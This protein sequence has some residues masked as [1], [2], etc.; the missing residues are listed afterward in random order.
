MDYGF[1]QD[2][3]LPPRSP[4]QRPLTSLTMLGTTTGLSSAVLTTRKGDTVHARIGY[5]LSFWRFFPCF[6]AFFVSK[7]AIFPLKRSVL[8]AW[9][10]NFRA[11]KRQMVVLGFQDPKTTWNAYKTREDVTTPQLA[12]PHGLA[13]KWA[14]NC[15]KTVEKTPKGQMV[16]NSRAHR[17][18]Y[19]LK[20]TN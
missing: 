2:P 13:S 12:S 15:Y 14:K 4:Q 10:G 16:P 11:R 1:L 19:T 20:T 9:K 8:A 17:R 3:H 5:H 7:L 6:A 18:H